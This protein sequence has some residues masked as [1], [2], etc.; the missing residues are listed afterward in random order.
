MLGGEYVAASG[1][2]SNRAGEPQSC[3]VSSNGNGAESGAVYAALDLGTNNCR[4]LIAESAP[5]GFRVV[6]AFSRI[7]RL[8]EQVDSTETLSDAAM[9]RTLGALRVCAEKIRRQS[10]T[11]GR[12]VATEACRRAR[13]GAEFLARVKSEIG[14]SLDIITAEEEAEL[15]VSGC[16]PLLDDRCDNA[17]VFDIGGG[18]TE[19]IWLKICPGS[20]PEVLGWTSL[21]CGVIT[22]T[23]RYGGRDPEPGEYE[24]MVGDVESRLNS[25]EA[26]HGLRAA[27]GG[28]AA[29]MLGISGTIT[30]MAAV[31]MDLPRYDR[32]KVDGAWIS[33]DEVTR[34]SKL[35]AAMSYAE[36]VAHPCIREARADLVLPGCAAMDAIIR[37]W[38]ADRVRVADRGLREGILL[39][40]MQPSGPGE[41]RVGT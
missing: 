11:H 12:Y 20:S 10:V 16:A 19:L 21:P 9:G 31:S 15:A 37:A 32:D 33:V 13:N 29:H 4:L 14:I 25:F 1:D 38:P 6:D 27:F 41:P 8:G 5:E 39:K 28:G 23:E 34:V 3:G 35:L 2:H 36:R 22:L 30:T 17:L 7:V 24:A 40:M 26:D 18:S